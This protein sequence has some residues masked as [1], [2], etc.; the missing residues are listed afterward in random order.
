VPLL[1]DDDH[2]RNGGDGGPLVVS[3]RRLRPARAARSRARRLREEGTVVFR[4]FALKAKHQR[5]VAL[6]QAAGRQGAPS[7]PSTTRCTPIRAARRS[8]PARVVKRLG[9]DL[10]RWRSI[11]ATRRRRG[12]RR[13]AATRCAGDD[14]AD[15]V[16]A[17]PWTRDG[18]PGARLLRAPRKAA[19]ARNA[20]TP[21]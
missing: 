1:R 4:H 13:D 8:A 3:L 19:G 17:W 2:V 5:A 9:L 21:D 20:R 7:G 15:P 18:A 11:A 16:F 12:V 10:D 6:A 14:D